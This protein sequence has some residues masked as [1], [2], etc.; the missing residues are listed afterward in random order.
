MTKINLDSGTGELIPRF[1]SISDTQLHFLQA[2]LF[3]A[4]SDTAA[5]T[6]RW[7]VLYLCKHPERQVR[8]TTTFM[9]NNYSSLFSLARMRFI[10][11]PLRR[12]ERAGGR[13][14]YRTRKTCQSWG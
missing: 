12:A 9:R 2:D 10:S 3:G 14:G 7:C 4:G 6:V 11:R 13:S 8:K 5:V 1:F